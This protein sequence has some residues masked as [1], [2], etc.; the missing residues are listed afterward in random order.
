MACS[1][2]KGHI[3]VGPHGVTRLSSSCSLADIAIETGCSCMH[4]GTALNRLL[5]HLEVIAHAVRAR[6]V[7]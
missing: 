6:F 5:R 2:L 3:L 7:A 1:E 4:A